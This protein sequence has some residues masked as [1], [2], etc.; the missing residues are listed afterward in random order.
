MGTPG[1][2]NSKALLSVFFGRLVMST[3]ETVAAVAAQK[4]RLTRLHDALHGTKARGGAP[5]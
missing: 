2:H 3:A 1:R 5:P 4:R